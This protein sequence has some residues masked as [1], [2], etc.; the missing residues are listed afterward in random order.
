MKIR[1]INKLTTPRVRQHPDALREYMFVQIT[2]DKVVAQIL[3]ATG[4][5]VGLL[6]PREIAI[7]QNLAQQV[8][9]RTHVG[10]RENGND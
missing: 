9:A 2:A 6:E 5:Y 4:E 8:F 3:G 1:R 10:K 7:L